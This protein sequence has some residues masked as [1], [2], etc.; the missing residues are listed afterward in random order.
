MA[1]FLLALLIGFVT[2]LIQAVFAAIAAVAIY[3][4][5]QYLVVPTFLSSYSPLAS[6][7][8]S[9]LFFANIANL[10]FGLSVISSAYV[11]RFLIRRFVVSL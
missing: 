8:P 10:Q 7:D 4:F 9:I 3:F 1:A 5:L 2:F 11:T 6:L